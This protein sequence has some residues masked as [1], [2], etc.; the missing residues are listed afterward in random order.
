[1]AK[2]D[3]DVDLAKMVGKIVNSDDDLLKMIIKG[4][5]QLDD[6]DKAAIR[7]LVDG[8]VNEM[9]KKNTPGE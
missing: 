3:A 9:N 1:M 7:K 4:Y 5:L 8:L 6:K 2:T